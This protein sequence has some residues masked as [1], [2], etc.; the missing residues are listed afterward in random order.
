MIE[1]DLSD[2]DWTLARA[3]EAANAAG[4]VL[5]KSGGRPVARVAA[6]PSTGAAR[7]KRL[8]F[9]RGQATIPD[10]FDTLAADEIA[11]SF[12]GRTAP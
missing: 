1:I 9:L 2:P 11:D 3:V 7:T 5:V 10:D 4:I 12:E 8:G 6:V